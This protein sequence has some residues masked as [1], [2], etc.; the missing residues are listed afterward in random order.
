[1][2]CLN[3]NG[4]QLLTETCLTQINFLCYQLTSF[5]RIKKIFLVTPALSFVNNHHSHHVSWYP[6]L[7]VECCLTPPK[8]NTHTTVIYD[9]KILY[10]LPPPPVTILLQSYLLSKLKQ[11]H[12]HSCK[13]W[14]NLSDEIA[15][16]RLIILFRHLRQETHHSSQNLQFATLYHDC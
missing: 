11:T 13:S 4:H 7:W 2:P 6:C 8:C 12:C 15:I 5:E 9:H 16:Y 14:Y 1:M 10:H 3:P